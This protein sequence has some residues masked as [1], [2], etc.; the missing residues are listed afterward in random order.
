VGPLPEWPTVHLD[1][2]YD[3]G[4]TRQELARRGLSGRIAE[5]GAPQSGNP[6]KTRLMPTL[7]PL[8]YCR[9]L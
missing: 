7:P 5:W 6:R 1:R 9:K 8:A 3:S 4:K 2:G